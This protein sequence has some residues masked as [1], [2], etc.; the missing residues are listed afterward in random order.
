[1]EA[2]SV[3]I[4][5]DHLLNSSVLLWLT[6]LIEGRGQAFSSSSGFFY[7]TQE[8]FGGRFSYSLPYQPIVADSSIGNAS[9]MSGVYL[10]RTFVTTGQSGFLD[11][12]YAKGSVYFSSGITYASNPA[13]TRISGNFCISEFSY[14]LT[15]E[16]EENLLFETKYSLKPKVNQTITGLGP[17]DATYPVIYVKP[18]NSRNKEFAMGGMEETMNTYRLVVLAES[19]FQVDAVT[20]LVRDRTRCIIPLL[21]GVREMPFNA[22]GGF[23]GPIYNYNTTFTGKFSTVDSAMLTDVRVTRLVSQGAQEL[24]RINPK[25]FVSLIDIDLSSYRQARI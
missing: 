11:I 8:V 1:M 25:V 20:S 16:P 15:N 10:D 4:Q 24:R 3:N 18:F 14:K 13:H 17:S 5:Y 22:Y 19:Q 6:N 9:V 23:S 2:Y 12:N 7:D 21:T